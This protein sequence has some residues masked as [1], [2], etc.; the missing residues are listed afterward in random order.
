[1]VAQTQLKVANIAHVALELRRNCLEQNGVMLLLGI[2]REIRNLQQKLKTT[3]VKYTH[4][5]F[6]LPSRTPLVTEAITGSKWLS[7][8]KTNFSL[9]V[10]SRWIAAKKKKT[11][12][13][14]SGPTAILTRYFSY[15]EREY[16][17]QAC[18]G[19]RDGDQM[20]PSCCAQWH[21]Q[22]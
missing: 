13:K 2:A 22:Q 18:S 11:R 1:M 14:L 9:T 15:Q 17:K 20:Y 7:L 8:L 21:D 10:R 16:D 4:T 5:E 3:A 12:W 19:T 6:T